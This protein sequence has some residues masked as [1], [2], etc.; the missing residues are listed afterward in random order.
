MGAGSM[1]G[2]CIRE[3]A[4]GAVS[5]L[6]LAGAFVY[7]GLEPNTGFLRG[8]LHLNDDRS[9]PVDRRLRTELPGVVAAGDV[10]EDAAGYGITAAG[11][12]ATAAQ[13]YLKGRAT[14]S[15]SSGP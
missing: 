2:V 8:Q 7:A 1:S 13:R 10:R 6:G 3:G 15:A 14:A 12:R 9:V 4:T 5:Q 11:D